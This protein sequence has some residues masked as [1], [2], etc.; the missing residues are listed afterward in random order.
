MRLYPVMIDLVRNAYRNGKLIAAI[1]HGPQLLISAKILRGKRVTS[2]PSIK[3]DL[4]NAGA[5][6]VDEPVVQDDNL[7][8]SRKPTDIPKFN[9]QILAYLNN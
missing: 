2:W 1:C 4:E 8:T 9:K 5:I 7:I 6:W 3:V